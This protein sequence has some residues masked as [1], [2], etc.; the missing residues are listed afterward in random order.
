MF[1]G[2]PVREQIQD[3]F[4]IELDSGRTQR[5]DIGQAG[6]KNA[7]PRFVDEEYR[8]QSCDARENTHTVV[9]YI[10]L[11]EGAIA[12]W[13]VVLLSDE[14]GRIAEEEANRSIS[15]TSRCVRYGRI[16]V[17]RCERDKQPAVC[18]EDS[19]RPC[20]A[21]SQKLVRQRT[22]AENRDKAFGLY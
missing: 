15:D 8:R 19:P 10:E 14:I 20:V 22:V 3:A 1:I 13:R 5:T 21:G 12:H 17:A 9:F 4:G 7:F 16:T 11:D 18:A 6:R 2:K